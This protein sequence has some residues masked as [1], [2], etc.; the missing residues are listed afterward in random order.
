MFATHYLIVMIIYYKLPTPDILQ[1]TQVFL[2]ATSAGASR[3]MTMNKALCIDVI[4]LPFPQAQ[5]SQRWISI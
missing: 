2:K 5:S 4:K 1:H 3:M